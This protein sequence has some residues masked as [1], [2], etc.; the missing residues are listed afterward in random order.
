MRITWSNRVI[1][2][3]TIGTAY[4]ANIKMYSKGIKVEIKT[5]AE[6]TAPGFIGLGAIMTGISGGSLT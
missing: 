4:S 2:V 6:V 3:L 5:Q 1:G